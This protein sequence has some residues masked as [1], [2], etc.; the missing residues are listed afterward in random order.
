[1]NGQRTVSFTSKAL[2]NQIKRYIDSIA[3]ETSVGTGM[4]F[5]ILGYVTYERPGEDVFQKDIEKEFNIRRS[6]ATG[7][8]QLMEKNGLIRR[9]PSLSDARMKRIILTD[10]AVQ[11]QKN[12]LKDLDEMERRLTEG[13]SEQ[14]LD[15]FYSVVEKLMR[16]IDTGK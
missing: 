1:M 7:I 11:I 12:L 9:E 2:A 8:L 3:K 16:N 4:Q 10:A 5:G 14:E 15:T 6:T 13:I